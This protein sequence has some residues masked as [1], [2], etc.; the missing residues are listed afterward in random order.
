MRNLDFGRGTANFQGQLKSRLNLVRPRQ[1]S[2]TLLATSASLLFVQHKCWLRVMAWTNSL[3]A[4][5]LSLDSS[6]RQH[7]LYSPG[8]S[9]R[10]SHHTSTRICQRHLIN[11]PFSKYISLI[12]TSEGDQPY[13]EMTGVDWPTRDGAG[14]RDYI[15]VWDLAKAHGAKKGCTLE[16]PW[17]K[18]TVQTD[19]TVEINGGKIAEKK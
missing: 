2:L 12:S 8:G 15:H 3:C 6:F 14:I 10:W 17:G 19:K 13:F 9:Q 18:Y 5:L 4:Q 7:L 11:K 1:R 16:G